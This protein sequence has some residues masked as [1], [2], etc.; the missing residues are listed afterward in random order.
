MLRPRCAG[1]PRSWAPSWTTR[2]SQISTGSPT[3][4]MA[5][6]RSSSRCRRVR[7]PYHRLPSNARRRTSWSS[8]RTRANAS[9]FS[10]PSTVTRTSRPLRDRRERQRHPLVRVSTARVLVARHEP[11]GVRVEC[12]RTR[13]Q[14]CGVAVGSE[15]EVHDVEAGEL[16]DLQLVRR[17]VR[18]RTASGTRRWLRRPARG[19]PPAPSARWSQGGRRNAPLVAPVDVDGPP[20]DDFGTIVRQPLVAAPRRCASTRR[21]R[22]TTHRRPGR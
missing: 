15:A 5:T 1:P 22:R 13:E 7:D 16:A 8:A 14:R 18:P 3:T 12:R 6:R 10:S 11:A 9:R 4:A 19:V 2:P 20:V 17:P 21:T